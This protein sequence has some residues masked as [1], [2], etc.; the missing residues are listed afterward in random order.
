MSVGLQTLL[1]QMP[2]WTQVCQPGSHKVLGAIEKCR[3]AALGYHLFECDKTNCQ[4]K[5][6][7][8][9]SCR[10]RHCPACGG[11]RQQAWVEARM[12]ELIPCKYFHVVFTLPHVLNATLLG[13]RKVMFDMLF[14]ATH[15]ALHSFGNDSKFMGGKAGIIS[16]LHT[17]GQNLSFHPHIHCIVS[18]GGIDANGLWQEAKKAK[19]GAL[20]PV[21]AMENVYRGRFMYLLKKAITEQRVNLPP[22]THYAKLEHDLYAKRW[23]VYAKQPFGGPQQVVEYLGR[24]THKVAISN[25]RI[26]SIDEHNNITFNYKDYADG[27]KKKLMT[28]SG[29][30]FLRRFEQ[31]ILPPGYCKI[32]SCG[33]YAN[34]GRKS[35]ITALLEQLDVPPHKEPV[36]TPWHVLLMERTGKD[37]LLCPC[38]KIG[39]LLLVEVV[40]ATAW[41]SQMQKPP[42]T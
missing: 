40:R 27:S 35:C 2:Q 3:T 34:H 6:M 38:C 1:R 14:E 12:R 26:K 5:Q 37:P 33:L 25:H 15:Y 20:Y 31:H 24:Y 8:F 16:I 36:K 17:W 18:G 7:Q 29:E 42:E 13:N 28:L 22:C 19:Y 39:R 4:N 9:H 30:E 11:S 10:N 23:V 21:Q 41:T 32:R